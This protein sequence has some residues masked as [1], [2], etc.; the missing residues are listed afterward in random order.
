M[1]TK[2]W[3]GYGNQSNTV[4]ICVTVM[5]K[6]E[7]P[8]EQS[9]YQQLKA[10]GAFLEEYKEEMCKTADKSEQVGCKMWVRRLQQPSGDSLV[11]VRVISPV[12]QSP[13]NLDLKC[14]P[15]PPL[16]RICSYWSAIW[17]TTEKERKCVIFWK[18]ITLFWQGPVP[19]W[20]SC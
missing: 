1:S 11:M 12:S 16:N 2:F 17:L 10:V 4:W 3:R 15:Q 9:Q 18:D 7:Y 19:E 14:I 5:Q 6:L 20:T 13:V 8:I